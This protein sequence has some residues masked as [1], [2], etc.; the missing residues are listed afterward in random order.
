MGILNLAGDPVLGLEAIAP[1]PS[2]PVACQTQQPP[3]E[4]GER[5]AEGKAEFLHQG[6]AARAFERRFQ[7][8]DHVQ[9]TGAA[10]ENGLLHIDLVRPEQ[11]SRVRNIEIK[12]AKASRIMDTRTSKS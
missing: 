7:L 12:P 9:V 8:A 6:I 3:C 10:L 2:A 11:E 5:K 1:L 4:Q